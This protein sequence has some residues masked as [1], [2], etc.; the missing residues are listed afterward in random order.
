MS[1]KEWMLT[2][3]LFAAEQHY[4][5]V[6]RSLASESGRYTVGEHDQLWED[7]LGMRDFISET[8]KRGNPI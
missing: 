6:R 5:Y 7:I 1:D 4:D 8:V 3:I 2:R